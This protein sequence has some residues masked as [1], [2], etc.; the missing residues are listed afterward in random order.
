MHKPAAGTGHIKSRYPNFCTQFSESTY[1][2]GRYLVVTQKPRIYNPVHTVNIQTR[3]FKTLGNGHCHKIFKLFVS[4]PSSFN[5][6]H[7]I[8]YRPVRCNDIV[9]INDILVSNHSFRKSNACRNY[10][11][12]SLYFQW[13]YFRKSNIIIHSLPHFYPLLVVKSDKYNLKLY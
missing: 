7:R 5:Y 8:P 6:A 2:S 10:F 11:C 3:S 12:I 13:L 1:G 9:F 4:N